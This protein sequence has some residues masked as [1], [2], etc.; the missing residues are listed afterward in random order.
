MKTSEIH[1]QLLHGAVGFVFAY[2][3][4][5]CQQPVWLTYKAKRTIEI[6]RKRQIMIVKQIDHAKAFLVSLFV[7]LLVLFLSLLLQFT[8]DEKGSRKSRNSKKSRNSNKSRHSKQSMGKGNRNSNKNKSAGS[9]NKK[10]FVPFELPEKPV[11]ETK[12]ENVKAS[13]K[14]VL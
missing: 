8:Q 3:L 10:V 13:F 7:G 12:P 9:K 6:G 2:M 4:I 11:N 14:F 1:H 5:Y